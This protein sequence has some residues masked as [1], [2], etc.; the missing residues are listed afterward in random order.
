M[1]GIS[2]ARVLTSPLLRARRTCELAGPAGGFEVEPDLAE[3]D[4]GSY[5]GRTSANILEERPG[6]NLFR[7]GAPDGE[8]PGQVGA[9]ADRLLLRLRELQGNVALFSHGH[10]GR[11]LAARWIG[12]SVAEAQHFLLATGSVSILAYEHERTDRPVIALWN[13][14]AGELPAVTT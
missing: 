9:R 6:W 7:D 2:F 12:I 13:S 5:E 3:W 8:T 14:E 11:V 4:Y 1:R 10:F